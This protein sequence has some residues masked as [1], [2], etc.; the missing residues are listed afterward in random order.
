MQIPLTQTEQLLQGIDF[1]LLQSDL[2]DSMLANTGFPA[3]V[4]TMNNTRLAGPI[5]CQI[6]G[7]T[8][9]AHSAFALTT[10]RQTRLDKA[11]MAGL[12]ASGVEDEEEE[13]GPIPKYPRGMLRFQLN[14]GSISIKAIEYKTLPQLELGETPLGYKVLTPTLSYDLLTNTKRIVDSQERAYTK[15]YRISGA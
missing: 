12:V 1:Q 4:A 9:I 2:R 8:E 10:V 14:D 13:D 5:L 7:L 15:G 3:N 11:D 6:T